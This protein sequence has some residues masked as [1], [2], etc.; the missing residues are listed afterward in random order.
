MGCFFGNIKEE[1]KKPAYQN[2]DKQVSRSIC[3]KEKIS[4]FSYRPSE[5]QSR[6]IFSF[7]DIMRTTLFSSFGRERR[8]WEPHCRQRMRKSMPARIISKVF[9]PQGWFFFSSTISPI[10]SFKGICWPPSAMIKVHLSL[11]LW[12]PF[13]ICHLTLSFLFRDKVCNRLTAW[14]SYLPN[15][16][17]LCATLWSYLCPYKVW[18][19]P[20]LWQNRL[21][22]DSFRG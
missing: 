17:A 10:L 5:L 9:P 11:F 18:E 12:P 19:P 15:F 3:G 4:V 8:I 13:F 7:G 22:S 6:E 2:F 1:K 21:R 14:G 20:E 16:I